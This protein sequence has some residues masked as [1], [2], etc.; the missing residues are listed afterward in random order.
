[1]APPRTNNGVEIYCKKC[2]KEVKTYITCF[3]CSSSYHFSCVL[4]VCGIFVD[5][6]GRLLCCDDITSK[7]KQAELEVEKLRT[8][9]SG[10]NELCFENSVSQ[11]HSLTVED[12]MFGA[13]N[14]HEVPKNGDTV[15]EK[16]VDLEV[17]YLNRI[18]GGKDRLIDE[19]DDK[20]KILKNYI[21]ILEK[22]GDGTSA[23]KKPSVGFSTGSLQPVKKSLLPTSE[24]TNS[25]EKENERPVKMVNPKSTV[26]EDNCEVFVS[27]LEVST[28]KDETNME[29]GSSNESM[30]TTDRNLYI[31][32][33]SENVADKNPQLKTNKASVRPVKQKGKY[34][35]KWSIMGKATDS[36]I[37]AIPK[38]ISLFVSRI[39]T[40]T[41][42]SEFTNMVKQNFT[43]AVCT[44]LNSKHPEC[45]RSYKVSIN[46]ENLERAKS[47]DLWPKDAYVSMFFHRKVVQKGRT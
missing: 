27:S 30:S 46:E 39:N 16:N 42:S 32:Q 5:Q 12:E 44:E 10:L 14:A 18:I 24:N 26:G 45:Y 19:L 31:K 25:A 11:L 15:E 3:R 13:D 21:S 22:F 20:I 9:L 36:S 33:T 7:L 37:K 28:N 34:D 43:E 6:K 17:E 38:T 35:N 47:C 4:K 23:S 8:R 40:Q 1:M 29:F 41:T 2:V